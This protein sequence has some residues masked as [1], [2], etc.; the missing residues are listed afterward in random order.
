MTFNRIRPKYVVLAFIAVGTISGLLA[1][2]TAT[3]QCSSCDT[4]PINYSVGYAPV[5]YTVYQPV[6]VQPARTGWYPGRWFE[7][8]RVA[9]QVAA[10]N[11]MAPTTYT[12]NYVPYTTSYA[13]AAP[14]TYQPYLTSYAPLARTV[15]ARP[16]VQ[17][18]YSPV[19]TS[20][21]QT[22]ALPT[23]TMLPVSPCNACG[24]VGGCSNCATGVSP[25]SYGQAAAPC[26]NCAPATSEIVS[27]TIVGPP[28]PQPTLPSD[29][30]AQRPAAEAEPTPAK[31]PA[32]TT[33]KKEIS[34]QP[35]PEKEDNSADSNTYFSPPPQTAGP[36]RSFSPS[37]TASPKSG[38]R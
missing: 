23:A 31:S 10:A 19:V 5:A 27:D 8:R 33:T 2:E 24:D 15:V 16:V 22:C 35:M 36:R 6:V 38:Q 32:E 14:V 28:T 30:N 25:A 4:Q 11:A 20:E 29:Y 12:T 34:P 13:P 1:A 9:R 37:S 17:A 3:A 21:C 7:R 18:V 26:S